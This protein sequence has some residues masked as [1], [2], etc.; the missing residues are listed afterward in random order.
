MKIN[1]QRKIFKLPTKLLKSAKWKLTMP[2]ETAMK[3]YPELIVTLADSQLMRWIDEINGINDVTAQI[4][5]L[6]SAIGIT[7]SKP[8][9]TKTKRKI[10]ELYRQL[11]NLLFQRDYIAVVMDSIKDYDRANEGFYVNGIKYRRLF[12]TSN[13]VKQK[14]IVYINAEIYDEI[15]KRI[16]N[17]RNMDMP[18]IPG[19]LEAYQSLTASGS[20]PLPEPN[21]IIVVPDCITHF[22]EDI[23]RISDENGGEPELT[24]E[25]DV[26]I[27]HNDSDGYGLML[28]SYSRRVN[29]FLSGSDDIISGMNTRFAFEKGM[30]YT[31]DF[32][33][34][35]EKIAGTYK[36]T[37]V[38]GDKRDVR[39]AEV[40]LT[41]SQL[42]LWD[43]Y[44][45]WE[46]YYDNCKKNNYQ[47]ATPKTTPAHLEHVRD[48]NY[49]FINPYSFS[50][51]DLSELVNPTLNTISDVMGG[52]YRKAIIYLGGNLTPKNILKVDDYLL[53]LMIA[54][55][56]INDTY[57]KSTIRKNIKKRIDEAKK[58]TITI[59][60]NYLM[61]SGDPYALAQS[62]FNLPITG[63][64]KAGEIYQKY[65][66]DK[67]SEELVCFRAPMT[68]FN[69]I[70]KMKLNYTDEAAHWYQYITTAL[71]Y[72]AWDSACDAM[73]GQDKDGDTNLITDNP[74]LLA[75]TENAK[76]IFCIQKKAEKKIVQEADLIES[77]KK[78]FNDDIGAIT[79]RATA[80]FDLRSRYAPD[81]EEYKTLT[82]RIMC[83]QH[84]QQCSI[85]RIKGVISLPMPEY[86]YRYVEGIEDECRA[87]MA[88]KKPYFMIYRYPDLKKQYKTY[89]KNCNSNAVRRFGMDITAIESL[90]K[91]SKEM[92]EFLSNYYKYFPV[93]DLDCVVNRI[94]RIVENRFKKEKDTDNDND[95][96]DYSVYKSPDITYSKSTFN[97][98]KEIYNEY[99]DRAS[100]FKRLTETKAIDKDDAD[101][102]Q[103]ELF[104]YFKM[105]CDEICPDDK[106]LCNIV[107]DM[108]YPHKNS[109]SFAWNVAG[110]TIIKNLIEK[111][112]NIIAY[113]AICDNNGDFLYMGNNY[114]MERI[115]IENENENEFDTE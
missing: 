42:K 3:D 108:C 40:I 85:D 58:G 47:F 2:L 23:I 53:A 37:D 95:K 69:N 57:I 84:Y 52:D 43:C 7:K 41:A 104:D 5:E 77:N 17:G 70:R 102:Q 107:L 93:S 99:I 46:D 10:K 92:T 82:Y 114:R 51:D 101:V 87:I 96:F 110:K 105:R 56:M 33:E 90:E 75:N 72:N 76:T 109:K 100:E 4:A 111:Y 78:A 35:A 29:S 1:R 15:I 94:A 113:P 31:F 59:S 79:N 86:W 38:W 14:T 63:L 12:G 81:S 66:I 106:V 74:V 68:C 98:I 91:P 65:W 50:D 9:T 115:K 39:N 54:P 32:I 18:L 27:E 48:L 26:E 89:T 28:P 88:D 36:I 55:E 13:G 71:I 20:V 11:N 6:K 61:V 19:K 60:G 16:N 30:I 25:N 83:T 21:G 112:G 67:G 8:V 22:K 34:F 49:Q 62:I 44:K 64:L 45:N 103:Q 80:M 73:N 97:H 24:Y